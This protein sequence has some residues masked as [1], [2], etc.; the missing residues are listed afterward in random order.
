MAGYYDKNTDYSVYL[1]QMMQS[2]ATASEVEH[3]LQQRVDKATHET[4][5]DKYAYDDI[6]KQA[7]EYISSLHQ[8][9]TNTTQSSKVDDYDARLDTA[10]DTL[11]QRDPFT[12]D[13]T[14]D[15]VFQSYQ[16]MYER[17]GDRARQNALGDAAT[18]TGGQVS[19]A[20][21]QAASQA[22]DYYNAKVGDVLPQ[23]Y[24]MAYDMYRAEGEDL[25]G[26]IAML[27]GL[28]ADAWDN[29]AETYAATMAQQEA[30]ADRFQSEMA[31]RE[32]DNKQGNEMYDRAMAFLNQG[33]MPSTN[34]LTAAGLDAKTAEAYRAAALRKL[35][36]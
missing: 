30:Q 3:V 11:E 7:K 18:L 1:K 22:Q 25:R 10:L 15:A 6:Y 17:E 32:S 2:G 21:M 12:Y 36:K 34:M 29:Q 20:A 33:V 9:S 24:S 31:Q 26:D 23:L 5:L 13:P 35:A 19:T 28:R 14:A 4:G 27:A 16:Q 8:A